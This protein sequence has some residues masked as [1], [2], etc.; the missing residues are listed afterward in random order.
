MDSEE[1]A[2][3]MVIKKGIKLSHEIL[4]ILIKNNFSEL[5]PFE[6]NPEEPL[7]RDWETIYFPLL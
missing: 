5:I 7:D 1:I 2:G 3:E 6:G 4:N